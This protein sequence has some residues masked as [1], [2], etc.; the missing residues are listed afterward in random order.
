VLIVFLTSIFH[1]FYISFNDAGNFY[2]SFNDA[3]LL[4]RW[5]LTND[6]FNPSILLLW[7]S[8]TLCPDV[9]KKTSPFLYYCR[10]KMKP[11]VFLRQTCVWLL[12]TWRLFYSKSK[13]D[14]NNP[15]EK[16]LTGHVHHSASTVVHNKFCFARNTTSRYAVVFEMEVL[17]LVYSWNAVT[18][19][20]WQKSNLIKRRFDACFMAFYVNVCHKNC[21]LCVLTETFGSLIRISFPKVWKGIDLQFEIGVHSEHFYLSFL[22]N[23]NCLTCVCYVTVH[24]VVCF[25]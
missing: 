5:L 6:F 24:L 11:K 16:L 20:A 19:R 25:G 8:L 12:L 2:I 21:F 22:I 4:V 14:R 1:F 7:I 15:V 23:H 9:M 3:W 10:K 17:R 13:I 18:P